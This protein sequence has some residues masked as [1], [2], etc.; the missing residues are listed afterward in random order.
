MVAIAIMG[1]GFVMVMQLFSGGLRAGGLSREHTLA[2]IHAK[3]K[4]EDLLIERE[5][6][7]WSGSGS[8]ASGRIGSYR[9]RVEVAPYREAAPSGAVEASGPK[10]FQVK[11]R[12]AWPEA[13]R[14][15]SVELVSLKAAP[16]GNR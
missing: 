1:I 16:G 11:V 9:W 15:R 5:A 10:L 12:V 4:L 14:E 6:G 8:A 2:V 7:A 13:E 3:E